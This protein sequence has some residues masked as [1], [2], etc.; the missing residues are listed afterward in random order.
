MAVALAAANPAALR[1]VVLENTF[2]SIPDMA[3]CLLPF[4]THLVGPGKPLTFL[5]KDTWRTAARVGAVVAPVLYICSSLDEMV[6]PSQMRALWDARVSPR[7][8]WLE[9]PSA[10][11]M[12]A[13]AVGGAKYWQG[14]V[15]F[16]RANG[17]Y[18]E[19][20]SGSAALSDGQH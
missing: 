4:L 8:V 2:T 10:H 9:F 18:D 5:V 3:G 16:L 19:Q 20:P 6:P 1:C 12:D 11:H 15:D 14:M 17:C 7:S 13:W